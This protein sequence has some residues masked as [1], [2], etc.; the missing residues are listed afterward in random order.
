MGR[1]PAFGARDEFLKRLIDGA[2]SY[3]RPG[4][5]RGLRISGPARTRAST[6]QRKNDADGTTIR[7]SAKYSHR[8]EFFRRLHLLWSLAYR[9]AAPG[10]RP[11]IPRRGAFQR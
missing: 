5:F 4:R 10:S 6:D 1:Q 7:T 3:A 2:R 8:G 9:P 11:S